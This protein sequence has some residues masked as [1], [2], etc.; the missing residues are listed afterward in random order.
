MIYEHMDEHGVPSSVYIF[1]GLKCFETFETQEA[2]S[3]DS[4]DLSRLAVCSKFGDSETE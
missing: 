3:R 2:Q 4:R 1:P